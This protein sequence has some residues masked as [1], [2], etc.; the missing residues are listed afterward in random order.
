M[1]RLNESRIGAV[2]ADAF[3]V[4]AWTG[5]ASTLHAAHGAP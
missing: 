4:R 2:I 5:T 1:E 3:A